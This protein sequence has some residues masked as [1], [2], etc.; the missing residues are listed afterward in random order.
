MKFMLQTKRKTL[1]QGVVGD[2]GTILDEECLHSF[3]LPL[4]V[5]SQTQKHTQ[6][7][8]YTHTYIN[9]Y[10]LFYNVPHM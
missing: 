8:T 4:P 7:Q 9:G 10:Y 1:R 2:V 5:F 6:T 3:I